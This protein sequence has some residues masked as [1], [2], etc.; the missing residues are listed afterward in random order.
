M[1]IDQA[2]SEFDPLDRELAER[3]LALACDELA[4]SLCDP[5]QHAEC[6][7]LLM[8]LISASLQMGASDDAHELKEIVLFHYESVKSCRKVGV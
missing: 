4:A 8:S 2:M 3:A 7:V 6:Q 5:A 1:Q